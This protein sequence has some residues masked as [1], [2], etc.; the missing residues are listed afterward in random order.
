MAAH[1]T[2]H[3]N[4]SSKSILK[5]AGILAA[6]G[7]IVR[8]IGLLYRSPLTAIIGDEGNGYYTVAYNIY[9]VV[10]LVSSYSI[11][12]AVS[13][14]MAARLA[15][16][17]Y[18]NAKR[19]FV[20]AFV[21]CLVVGGVASLLLYFGAP[22]LASHNL[23]IPGAVPVLRIFAPAIFFFGILG[24]L[25]GYFQA[26][27]TMLQTSVSQIIEQIMNAIMSLLMAHVLIGMATSDDNTTRAVYGA[28]GSAI[29]TGAGVF[30]ALLFMAF[31][32]LLSKDVL[33][34]RAAADLND[35]DDYG[36]IFK[37]ILLFVTPFILST[38][39]YN[40]TTTLDQTIFTR[41]MFSVRGYL[42]QDISNSYG[43]FAG[44]AVVISNIPIAISTAFSAALMP[45]ISG[46]AAREDT[47][48]CARIT[49][50]TIRMTMLIAIP[51]S[52]GL[53]AL[54]RPVTM[55]LFPQR[56]SLD[57]AALLLAAIAVTVIFYSLSTVTNGVLQ[58]IGKVNV[59][60][61]HAGIALIVQGALLYALLL[62]TDLF[63]MA[64][65]IAL[66]VYSLLVCVLNQISIKRFL[67]VKM[68]WKR[69]YVFPAICAAVMG[70]CAFLSYRGLYAVISLLNES[71][72][73]SNLIALFVAIVIAVFVYS[74][75]LLK[76]KIVTERD[77]EQMP[78]GARLRTVAVKMRML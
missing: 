53:F 46:A 25:R 34:R 54:A 36:T 49:R 20:C 37:S 64:L 30:I 61:I 71:E 45:N 29:G 35:P 15:K 21:Y 23:L 51:A 56:A 39:I 50:Q 32:Y 9:T 77:L 59:P 65:V 66:I 12:S 7:I 74:F 38:F 6:A 28:M 55:V 43:I 3:G 70:G 31:L 68:G 41:V 63:S 72:Y 44:K 11:P 26:H 17:E 62:Y 78:G 2:E 69:V 16:R 47:K 60:V 10:L 5:Q 42:E 1:N 14:I 57:T 48:G 52:V 13:K 27:R 73:F 75:L 22:F 33:N 4:T 19:I 67:H 8:I 24:V 40:F 58:G 76:L 18:A